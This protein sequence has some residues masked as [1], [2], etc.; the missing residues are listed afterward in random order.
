MRDEEINSR[1]TRV[2]REGSFEEVEWEEVRVGDFVKVLNTEIIPA[3][4][5]ILPTS[6][7][8]SMCYVETANLDGESNLKEKFAFN[9]GIRKYPD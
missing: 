5:L 2:L 4:L 1:K 7:E 3:D 8:N 6:E 9:E